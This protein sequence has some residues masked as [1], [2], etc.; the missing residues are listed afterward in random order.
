MAVALA[1][2]SAALFAFGAVLQQRGA[3]EQQGGGAAILLTLARRP[4]WLAGIAAYGV[5]YLVQCAALG[6]GQLV[7]VQPILATTIVFALPLGAWLSDQDIGRRDVAAAIAVTAGLGLFLLL[8]DPEGGR[9][10]APGSQWLLACGVVLAVVAA[11]TLMGRRGAGSPAM[12]AALYGTAAGL[13]FGLV[14]ALTKGAVEILEDGNLADVFTDWHIYAVLV[15][16]VVGMTLIQWSFQVGV[17]PPAVATSSIFNPALSVVL[18]LT[19]FQETIH[20]STAASIG[21]VAALMAMFAGI[22][23]LAMRPEATVEPEP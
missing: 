11:L 12:R 9:E 2:V 3:M 17:L 15:L 20:S 14:S 18:G 10:D 6:E 16:G 5:A 19:L 23:V 21:A 13:T 8:A 7:V 22:A 4:V 1:L